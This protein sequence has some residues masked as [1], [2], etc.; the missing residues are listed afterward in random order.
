V[1]V[2]FSGDDGTGSGIASC[3]S[4]VVLSSE[5]AG[6]SATGSCTDL[7]GNSA[8]ATA[9]GIN[10]DKT[11]PTASANASPAPNAS[12][13]NNTD[14]TVTF[15][16]SDALSGVASCDAPVVLSSDGAGQSASGSCTDNA[17]NV[18][19]TATASGINIDQ[20]AP[21]LSPSVSPNPVTLN[22]SA[23]ASPNASDATSGLASASCD[24][25]DTSSI[26]A[27][28]VNCT[29]TDNAG[30]TNSVSASYSV[31][32]DWNGFFQPVD[33]LP[34]LNKAK[35]GS[36]IPVKFSLNGYQGLTI[37][38]P[39][40]PVSTVT[41]CGTTVTDTI[42]S[43]V[44]AGSSSLSYDA[45]ADQYNYVWKTDKAWAG[46]CR[47]LTVKLIDGTTHQANF[48]FTK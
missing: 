13:W 22:G 2:T 44:T 4:D 40:Y 27:H 33:N 36:A 23:T 42:E 26:G 41:T 38:L 7:A 12:G 28:S 30:N 39:G 9:S 11:A 48:Q 37:F 3:D 21:T 19:A 17:G 10:I 25:V 45:T 5:G 8:S 34:A 47:T 1:T 6:Q 32:Y 24:P 29:A 43:T 15:S 31:V 20:T 18:S 16:G 14:V 46:S 35:A